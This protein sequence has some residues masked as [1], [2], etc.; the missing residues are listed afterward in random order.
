MAAQLTKAIFKVQAAVSKVAKDGN[1]PHTK[2]KFPTLEAVLDALNDVLQENQLVLTQFTEHK[3][4]VG[5]VLRT[6]LSSQDGVEQVTTNTPLLGLEDSSN[7]MQALG[8]AIT[9]ARR[10]ALMS[11]FKLAPTDDDGTDAG[12]ADGKLQFVKGSKPEEQKSAPKNFA[13]G[14]KDLKI[15]DGRFKGKKVSEIPKEDLQKYIA[16]I[17]AATAA[18]GKKNSKWFIDLKAAVV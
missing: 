1:N 17:E 13:P 5:W 14:A 16:E 4:A 18:A 3:E 12:T 11:L 10:Y 2:S 15:G 9:Y 8:S 7:K 6:E